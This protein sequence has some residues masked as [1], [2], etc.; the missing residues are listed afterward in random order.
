MFGIC[1]VDDDKVVVIE[2][3]NWEIKIIL[4]IDDNMIVI[5]FLNFDKVCYGI[6][7][8][9]DEF[10]VLLLMEKFFFCLCIVFMNG[11]VINMVK[12][13]SIGYVMFEYKF[14]YF[15]VNNYI[16]EICVI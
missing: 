6:E 12:K 15:V 4:I 14:F 5:R 7:K 10:V 2:F 1:K 16:Y 3:N 11:I 9:E 13:D 8:F